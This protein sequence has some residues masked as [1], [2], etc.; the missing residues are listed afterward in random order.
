MGQPPEDI[1]SLD[2][3]LVRLQKSTRTTVPALLPLHDI[4]RQRYHWY[5]NWHLM[6]IAKYVHGTLLVLFLLLIGG[7]SYQLGFA[8]P[9]ITRAATATLELKSDVKADMT[10]TLGEDQTKHFEVLSDSNEATFLS[11]TKK[12][13]ED[14]FGIASL[15]S[16]VENVSQITIQIKAKGQASEIPTPSPTATPASSP[17]ITPEP[18]PTE[19]PTPAITPS[20][21]AAPSPTETVTATPETILPALGVDINIGGWQ[22][23]QTKNLSTDLSDYT[24]TFDGSWTKQEIDSMQ[25]KINRP[26]ADSPAG[27]GAIVI[28][29]LSAKVTYQEKE[30]K[31]KAEITG[32][33]GTLVS[34]DTSE[35]Y[36]AKQGEQELVAE[37]TQNFKK[38]KE[39]DGSFRVTGQVGP[40]HYKNDPFN[41]T[42]QYKEIDLT[43][44]EAKNKSWDYE[45]NNNGYQARFWN[46]QKIQDKDV[47]Y[48]AEYRR[49]GKWLKMAPVGLY[50]QNKAGEQQ[51]IS[52]PQD[53]G[54]PTI[55]NDKNQVTWTDA[56]GPGLDFRY[57]ISPDQFFKTLIINNKES[58]PAPT[59][60]TDGLE[61][62][63]V[64]SI[65]WHGWTKP[66]KNFSNNVGIQEIS[67]DIPTGAASEELN[68]PQTFSFK[69]E[70]GH[71][72]WWLEAPKAWDS[73][74]G[75][76][77]NPGPNSISMSWNLDR[78]ENEV[79][80]NF[81]AS[82]AALDNAIFPVFIDTDIAQELIS[83]GTN[84]AWSGGGGALTWPG[85]TSFFNNR[86][87]DGVGWNTTGTPPNDNQNPKCIG[88]RF[89]TIPVPQGSLINHASLTAWYT[90]VNPVAGGFR[91]YGDD[92]DS[93]AVWADTTSVD[94]GRPGY[95]TRTAAYVT[96][97]NSGWTA[98]AYNQFIDMPTVVSEITSRAT[99]ASNNNMAF[100]LTS[101]HTT[102]PGADEGLDFDT[103][104]STPTSHP[105][106]LNI[107]YGAPT[108]P[109]IG[110]A[111]ALST[112]S[113]RWGFTDT[114]S[115]ETGFK[116]HDAAHTV[117]ATCA[118]ANLTYCDETGLAVNTI[119]TRHVVAYN[120]AG[121]SDDSGSTSRYTLANPPDAAP[122]VANPQLTS[123]DVTVN[124]TQPGNNPA[125]TTYAFGIDQNSDG[126]VDAG[127][128]VQANGTL[129]V[130]EIDQSKSTWG[131]KTVTGLTSGTLYR[132]IVRAH[133]GND[134]VTAY[135]AAG[136]GTTLS[137]GITIGGNIYQS[138][139]ESTPDTTSYTIYASVNNA[140]GADHQVTTNTGAYSISGVD[141]SAGNPI[142][143]YIYNHANNAN[144]FT[145]TNGTSAITNL[146]LYVNKVA[147]GNNNSGTTT[148]ANVCAQSIY[149]GAA[150]KLFSCS[151]N[152]LTINSG[153][154]FHI[155]QSKSW[156][157]STA[158]LT[159]QGTGGLHLDDNSS[160]N[161]AASDSQIG[162][163]NAASGA[164]TVD[165][166]ATLSIN[167]ST[168]LKIG[169]DLVNNGTFSAGGGA[170]AVNFN[171]TSVDQ[172]ISGSDITFRD[173]SL[174]N[175]GRTLNV[176]VNIALNTPID[177]LAVG[178][179]TTLNPG[180][181]KII[182]G[183]TGTL[184]GTGTINVSRQTADALATQYTIGKTLTNLTV[185]YTGTSA[186][187][188][189][190]T[191]TTY[192]GLKISGTLNSL[193]QTATVGGNFNVT[194]TFT[195][196]AS[197]ITMTGTGWGIT[198]SGT[199]TFSG[200][201][202]A[203]TPSSQPSASF[204]VAAALTVNGSTNFYPADPSVITFT[205]GSI[206]NSGN[207][208][209]NSLTIS[210]TTTTNSNFT[211]NKTL[212][213]GASGVFQ[214]SGGTITMSTTSWG[215]I[216]SNTYDKLAFSG[217]TISETP[218]VSGQTSANFSITGMLTV[219]L[220]KVL[221]PAGGTITMTGTGWGITN[222]GGAT[223]N[224][225][226]SGLTVA[227]TP[228]SQPSANF[229]IGAALTVNASQSLIPTGTITMVGGSI[230]NNNVLTFNNLT[231]A[232]TITTSSSF[233]V[234]GLMT[235]N[236]SSSFT[237]SAGTI[238]VAT[239]NWILGNSSGNMTGLQFSGLT[240]SETPNTASQVNF[241]VSGTL[242]V[243][244]G[245]TFAP[246]AG[247]VTMTSGS[248]VNTDNVATH[249][250]FYNLTSSGAVANSTS[251]N[252]ANDFKITASTF[253]SSGTPTYTVSGNVDF[254]GG[255]FTRG[256]ST[257]VMNGVSKNLIAA[258]VYLNNIQISGTVTVATSSVNVS[259]IL[260]VDNNKTLTVDTGQSVF[261]RAGSTT[262]LAAG[263]PGG[264]IASN[265]TGLI[266]F[267]DTAGANLATTGTLSANVIFGASSSAVTI[268]A[269]IYG[270][271]VQVWGYATN[272]AA[273]L[274]S[275]TVT[276][277]S[278][279]Y[280]RATAAGNISLS[281]SNNPTVNVTGKLDFGK[282]STGT[283]SISM[284][285]NPWTVNGDVD[286]TSGSVTAGSG[287]NATLNLNGGAG[288]TQT[289]TPNGQTLNN[290]S[291]TGS[292]AR[293]VKFAGSSTLTVSGTW[294]VTGAAGQLIILQSTDANAWTINPTAANVSYANVSKSNS[295]LKLCAT[296]STDGTGNNSNW[297]ISDTNSCAPPQIINLSATP[298]GTDKIQWNFTNSGTNTTSIKVYNTSDAQTFECSG[299]NLTSCEETGLSTNSIY[300]RKIKAVNG[301]SQGDTFSDP[302]LGIYTLAAQPGDPTS[303]AAQSWSS[304]SGNSV[305]VTLSAN[306]NPDGTDYE[307]YYDT[308]PEGTF[309]T[310]AQTFTAHNNGDTVS[311][312]SLPADTT[313]YYKVKARNHNNV[314]TAYNPAAT[315]PSTMTAPAKPTLNA[316]LDTYAPASEITQNKITWHWNTNAVAPGGYEALKDTDSSQVC[317]AGLSTSCEQSSLDTNTSY[318]VK[319]RGYRAAITGEPSVVKSAY[320]AIDNVP[321]I[322]WDET[323]ANFTTGK[324]TASPSTLPTNVGLGQSGV[325]Y[326]I[327]NN[328]DV[329]IGCKSK[330]GADTWQQDD[331]AQS[332]T[333]LST[334]ARYKFEI[335]A[336][337]GN[338]RLATSPTSAQKY[339][340]IQA[341]TGITAVAAGEN[342]INLTVANAL[343]NLDQGDSGVQFSESLGASGGGGED[344][345][346]T[347][348]HTNTVS[349]TGL[350][351]NTKYRY[352]VNARNG[353][354]VP[355]LYEGA[356]VNKYTKIQ[357][358]AN[359]TTGLI[360]PNS[361]VLNVPGT[362][363]NLGTEQS[364][365]C[366]VVVQGAD[367]G[368]GGGTGFTSCAQT[369]SV[370]DVGLTHDSNFSYKVLAKNGDGESTTQTAAI[371]PFTTTIGSELIYRL[372]GQNAFNEGNN[373]TGTPNHRK[374]G[375]AFNVEMYAVDNN[376]YQDADEDH[377]VNITTNA[378]S[379][380][381]ANPTLANGAV[382]YNVTI[383]SAGTFHL[384]GIGSAGSSLEFIVDPGA[385]SATVST[386]SASPTSLDVEQTS[387]ATIYL[388]DA[389]GN[390]LAG[391]AVSVSSNQAVGADTIVINGAATDANGRITATLTGHSAHTSTITVNDTTDAV[392][393]AT[394]PQITFNSVS[395]NNPTNVSATASASACAGNPR[396][397]T[398]KIDLS[399]TNPANFK[400]INIY[401]SETSGV[402]GSKIADTAGGSYTDNDVSPGVT[403]FY[404]LEAEDDAGHKSSGTAQVSARGECSCGDTEAP[405]APSNLRA[406]R[407]K[408][409]SFSIAWDASRDN[410]GVT[411]YQVYNA[412]TGI[413]VGVTAETNYDFDNLQ[414][415]T[416][417]KLHVRAYDADNNFSEF[418][419]VLT[420]RTL[421]GKEIPPEELEVHLVLSNVPEQISAGAAFSGNIRVT[422]ADAGG[423]IITDYLKAVYFSSTDANAKLPYIK[424]SP[425]TYTSLDGGIHQFKGQ[426]FALKTAGNQKLIVSDYS[427]SSSANIKVIAGVFINQTADKIR[428][429]ISKPETVNKA[430]TAVVTTTAAVLLAPVV[431]NAIISFSSL[432]PQIFYW[433][434]QLL[435]LL[436]IRKR[437]KPWGVIFNAETGQPIPLAMVRIYEIK[438]NR[439]L[440]RV[441]TD[442]QGRYGFLVKPGEFYITCSKTGFVFPSKDKKSTFYE[443][444]YTGGN[445][446][447]ADKD[448]TIAFNIP[449]DPTSSSKSIVNLWIWVT[450]INK[451]LQKLRV[452]LLI[453][454]IVFAL[455][456]MIVSFNILYVLSLGFYV[457][458]GILEILRGKKARPYGVV[459]DTYNHPISLSIVRI[460]KKNNNQLIETDVSDNQGRF[461]FLVA[462]GIYY[463]TATK[464]GYIDFKSHLMYLEKEKTLVST[465]IKLKKAEK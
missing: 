363:T 401:R 220:G 148:N 378:P 464:P 21:T 424:D 183:A 267:F 429:F 351:A 386:V 240:I 411:G 445:F 366:F 90:N 262:T 228:S 199:L 11:A 209:F 403:Y 50:W 368:G 121:D 214:P 419:E 465:T 27:G 65:A 175:T 93:A 354:Q 253:T 144:T 26:S 456:M 181:T 6:P 313:I 73:S 103:F 189:A 94:T 423:K 431:A 289:V 381:I 434:T 110:V 390:P 371:G 63:V 197:T 294:T 112:T 149:P 287:V 188:Q 300:T 180:A 299:A 206:S 395:P 233:T 437:A 293:T 255:A 264:T 422:A 446:K 85:Y 131:T 3:E 18:S 107:R 458:I 324:L 95:R 135:T 54:A 62:N 46:N 7:I 161:F 266:L 57:N 320:T 125:I 238:T 357:T 10:A 224:L 153:L 87:S 387:T 173:L 341:P 430:N 244:S 461:K 418:S 190:I 462:P 388:K 195:P 42:E 438:Y 309:V 36:K 380:T 8:S 218:S 115:N 74:K 147:I 268:P 277:L 412:E 81:K 154:E 460:Y 398:V 130:T 86:V 83:A 420:V 12:D 192:G 13:Q 15:G 274:G 355:A 96:D 78:K 23:L 242:T 182:S 230:T 335:K 75:T 213:I 251:F 169:G 257:V 232:G 286:F 72:I 308:D 382:S 463:I 126:A 369:T 98:G 29:E 329:L 45:M 348:I 426:D 25:I 164:L 210:A 212:T 216:N 128:W 20:P 241:G 41:D 5:Y 321:A 332:Q 428:D 397:C 337:N 142:A 270:G 317:D 448:Q 202:I 139:S 367:K 4:L 316:S 432:L 372:P 100:M 254:T 191:N 52:L 365:L 19:S 194:G 256:S 222:N 453:L 302:P 40:I 407:I 141:A 200:L 71:D 278:D 410:V 105:A 281:G 331:T 364:G 155:L 184:T 167:A 221:A 442:N 276:F 132:F 252:V 263:T 342:S 160:A 120:A 178:A 66:D 323:E 104:E 168:G 258:G 22:T 152:N 330:N 129:G 273:T 225:V 285:N 1:Q 108:A 79:F 327:Y 151:G 111:T 373:I 47:F 49:D 114:A 383:N 259:G 421:K 340:K 102:Y 55:D 304:G 159:T 290:L 347:W 82:A 443:K 303:I 70:S 425:Y 177:T 17:S 361:M 134:V 384:D 227:G 362:Y 196:A 377:L 215:I 237:A 404:T 406:T 166:G 208:S 279:L 162:A 136:T 35:V 223:S 345:F 88:L 447:I 389:S 56:F 67:A 171:N 24:F 133:N 394:K 344:G 291:I 282:S 14:I 328:S 207:L 201:T 179:N 92:H 315:P 435:Q 16:R 439:I 205:G 325:Q 80:A 339:T 375:E 271:G 272:Y 89:L 408:D 247:T 246:S 360:T 338:A 28:S 239:V 113:I 311:Q 288:S 150:D 336:R 33:A 245:K 235:V 283:P 400:Q 172:T 250:V 109:T 305:N 193:A 409:T 146:H 124:D 352:E 301:W 118:S 280:I 322:S 402:R 459:T 43:V 450:R 349:D 229:S 97:S 295:G 91:V 37:R 158:T 433:L 306:G 64:M 234:N 296:Y 265:T 333:A 392:T 415:D 31:T 127:G 370:T 2:R 84:D 101:D 297:Y 452:P 314:V 48:V 307:I 39:A 203:G 298:T 231:A 219:N 138:G 170:T 38:F 391:H 187:G 359:I 119:Y 319:I 76:K 174:S 226:F 99:W 58:L 441:V 204:S 106:K 310:T 60:G 414:P 427:V 334:N 318:G 379:A 185:N 385:C 449:L 165:T 123:L 53:V 260:T 454:G 59:I 451:L 211:I 32:T 396:T 326:C 455:I 61:L 350:S 116:V 163:T 376:Y 248:I 346:L 51:L 140:N 236:A 117:V 122:T 284:G 9:K 143:V 261:M 145:V 34:K 405:T 399:W 176:N 444:I 186:G 417:Y 68:N 77:Q 343:S 440:E 358:P 44:S 353:D 198:R 292:N 436:G 356:L 243:N 217:L 374:A 156:S 269:R 393:L 275:G 30:K 249:L 157:S 69:D 413:M 416:V 312:T 137:A 457:L